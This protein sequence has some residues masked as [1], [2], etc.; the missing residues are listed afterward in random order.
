MDKN[1]NLE[2]QAIADY[3]ELQKIVSENQNL[4]L[5]ELCDKLGG[6][7]LEDDLF[8]LNFG[9]ICAT[10][11]IEDNKL[12]LYKSVEIWNDEE[13]YLYDDNF[14]MSEVNKK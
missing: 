1:M 12:S 2:N 9:C 11:H 13:C 6:H 10:I 5:E 7:N 14:D 3:K 8:D 4:T